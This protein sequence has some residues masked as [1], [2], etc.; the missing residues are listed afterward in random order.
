MKMLRFVISLVIIAGGLL[1]AGSAIAA[2]VTVG[3]TATIV[4]AAMTL[5]TNTDLSMGSIIADSTAGCTVTLNASAGAATPSVTAGSCSVAG[6]NSGQVTVGTNIDATVSV[7]YTVVGTGTPTAADQLE[8]LALT[9]PFTA[10][11]I[12]SNS[13][14]TNL[15]ITVAGPNL[16]HVG[17]VLTVSAAQAP[18][19]YTG[20][21]T[22]T[23]NY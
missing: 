11:N 13:T 8:S 12:S 22:V 19:T 10:A 20:D 7:S 23:V 21:I 9:M 14:A 5:T 6:G 2:T 18:A 4:A 3:A 15:P 17:G 16:I 1:G